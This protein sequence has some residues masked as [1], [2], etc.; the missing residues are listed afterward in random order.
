MAVNVYLMPAGTDDIGGR[1]P[2]YFTTISPTPMVAMDYGDEPVFL[3]AVKDV[4]PAVHTA[5]AGFS[6]VTVVPDLQQN[7]GAQLATVQA[8]L[9][10]F[11]I[12]SQWVTS[13]MSYGSVCRYVAIFFLIT[14]VLTQRLNR[15]R[16]F[17]G[18]VTLGTTWNQLP[19]GVRTD[20]LDLAAALNFDTTGMSGS[21]TVRQI[22]KALADQ[23]PSVSIPMGG[24]VL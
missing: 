23:W 3:V 7:V 2:K 4:P 11:N 22:L 20:L 8:R 19:Q 6:D 9:D 5:L 18:S 13:G 12:P 10:S 16:L 21:T 14:Q 17:G 1:A 15:P 24:L